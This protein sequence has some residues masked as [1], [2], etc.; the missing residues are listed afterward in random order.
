[1]EKA[2]EE[3]EKRGPLAGLKVIDLT[4]VLSGPFATKWLAAMGADVI[5]VENPKDPDITRSYYPEV[6]GQ[7][8]YFPTVNHNKRCIT[9]NLKAEQGKELLRKLVK[10]ADVVIENFRPGVMEKLGLGY[11][12]LA[13]INP[14]LIYASISGY[15]TYGPYKDRPGYDVTAQAISGLMYLTGYPD[16]APTRVGSSF[17]DTTAGVNAVLAI[18]AALYC[19]SVTGQ[20]QMVET[21]LV[22]SL[23][24]LSTQDYIRYFAAGEVPYRMGN[25]YK[26]WTPY[27][28]Y[29]AKD[30]Y[31][32]VGCGTEKHFAL[33][34]AVMGKPE[35]AEDPRFLSHKERVAHRQ[36]LDDIINDWAGKKTVREV[37]ELLVAS[38]VP[39]GPVN[40]IVEVSQ[41]EHIAGARDMFPTLVQDGIGDLR[42]TNIPVRFSKSGLAPLQSAHEIGGDNES[43]YEGLG[44]SAEEITRLRQDGVI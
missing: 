42:I 21:S 20:G 39:C 14:G 3:L 30:G 27:G 41:D 34:C 16:G 37:C 4:R 38:G 11:E 35:L 10:D 8:A 24:S 7:S 43:V 25:I 44:L 12:A 1:M 40:S 32:N 5:K 36:E 28:T 22:D 2:M 6:N 29:Q 33:F 26:T 9:L 13:K 15:G 19:R 18:L 31:Y 23:I 17:G